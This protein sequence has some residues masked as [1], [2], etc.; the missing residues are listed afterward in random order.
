MYFL[1]IFFVIVFFAAIITISNDLHFLK[2][3]QFHSA[4]EQSRF[5]RLM[6]LIFNKYFAWRY[7][8]KIFPVALI[9][10]LMLTGIAYMYIRFALPKIPPVPD[11]VIDHHDSSL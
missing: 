3:K 4:I 10:F 7:W 2:Q 5:L 8:K 6:D 1:I 11:I 9:V